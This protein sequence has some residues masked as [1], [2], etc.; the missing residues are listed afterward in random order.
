MDE[1]LKGKL[2][3]AG[4]DVDGAMERFMNNDN[5]FKKFQLKFPNDPN[6]ETLREGLKEKDCDKAFR[7]AHTLKGVCG[8]LSYVALAKVTSEVTEYLRAGDMDSAVAKMPDMEEEYA[9]IIGVITTYL[10]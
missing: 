10:A 9:R 4:I 8:N 5:M 1:S 7:A 6:M 2:V 3:E